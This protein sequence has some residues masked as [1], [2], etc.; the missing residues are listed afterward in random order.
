[1]KSI[2]QFLKGSGPLI[3]LAFLLQAPMLDKPFHIDDPF[4]ISSAK[5][6]R[7][8]PMNPYGY[9]Y[10]WSAEPVAMWALTHNPPLNAYLLAAVELWANGNEMTYHGVYFLFAAGSV[11]LT[12]AL[13]NRFCVHPALATLLTL[14]TPAF[15]ICGSGVMAEI[16]LMFFWLL[17]IMLAVRALD[18]RRSGGF[19]WAGFAAALAVM[20]K[21]IGISIVP[22][23]FGYALFRQRDT[24]RQLFWGLAVPVAVLAGWGLYSKILTGSFHPLQAA[25]YSSPE[26]LPKLDRIVDT[27]SFWSG[28][29]LWPLFV[30]PLAS[31]LDS[32]SKAVL[33]G[34]LAGVAAY[35]GPHID[36]AILA[37]WM[38]H[39]LGGA[40]LLLILCSSCRLR[41]DADS[42]FLAAWTLVVLIYCAFL[43]WMVTARALLLAS[44]PTALLV[45]RWIESLERRQF[46]IRW[47]WAITIPALM[48]SWLV[49]L[50][51]ADFAAA[52][53][54][55]AQTVVREWRAQGNRVHFAGHWGFQYYMEKEGT[56][57]VNYRRLDL[58][59]GDLVVLPRNNSDVR[60]IPLPLEPIGQ[61]TYPN[62]YRIAVQNQACHAGFYSALDGPV[63]FTFCRDSIVDQ[64]T[65]FRFGGRSP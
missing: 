49:A 21:Y 40:S 47:T 25:A 56:A 55:F 13:A 37:W 53:R 4:F 54:H 33:V 30:I 8:D 3:F 57:P 63:A 10:N 32:R 62:R 19:W 51:D 9:E 58:H 34:L 44:V 46:C 50:A 39:Q 29:F 43:N 65:V 2:N 11:A 18:E 45:L 6:I 20:T 41:P 36:G 15:L 27:L 35:R 24:K 59:P 61:W 7:A 16:P 1:M 64:F 26:S 42:L 22:L 52:G 12:Y 17:A 31:W 28:S 14:I 60:P 48:L 5:H 23:L 38:L